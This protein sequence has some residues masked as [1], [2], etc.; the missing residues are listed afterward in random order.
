MKCQTL[1]I[2]DSRTIRRRMVRGNAHGSAALVLM[3]SE[4]SMLLHCRKHLDFGRL[5]HTFAAQVPDS[6]GFTC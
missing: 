3:W 1:A 2:D 5:C 6:A 4:C